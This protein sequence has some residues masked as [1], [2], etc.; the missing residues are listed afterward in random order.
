MSR[1][2]FQAQLG[3]IC[4]CKPAARWCPATAFKHNLASICLQASCGLVSRTSFQAQLGLDLPSSWLRAGFKHKLASICLQAGCGL[5][6][7]TSK[8][9]F[10]SAFK[11]AAG[12]CPALAFKHNLASI[13]L[14]A[15]CGLVS[16]TSFQAQLGLDLPSS[17]LRAGVPHQLSSTTW[18]RSASSWLRAG[19]PHQLSSTTWPR[20]ASS[21]LRAGVP[22]QLSSTTWP[23][24]FKHNLA[25]SFQ[26]Q[27]GLDRFKLAAG[28][29]PAPAFKHNLASICLQAGCGLVSRTSKHWFP[30]AFKL[31]ASW[32]PAPAF[33]HN[34]ASICLQA[35]CAAFEA[36]FGFDRPSGCGCWA[37]HGGTGDGAGQRG[38]GYISAWAALGREHVGRGG[39]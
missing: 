13:C 4:L 35:G 1:T 9:W 36:Q 27:L 8:H 26:A 31:A 39:G 37:G 15:G 29:C 28:W 14:Q 32:C 17:W 2:G 21:W 12:W 22:H 25:S 30:S 34:L 10:P 19:V 6:S 38:A 7:R 16:R 33:K 23:P 11:L 5:V 24:A 18:P 20:S 3:P